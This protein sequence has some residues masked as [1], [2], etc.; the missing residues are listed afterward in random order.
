MSRKQACSHPDCS[1]P[2][3]VPV[4]NGNF[5]CLR[6]VTARVNAPRNVALTEADAEPKKFRDGGGKPS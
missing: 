5:L 1:A 3:V 2:G 4:E 6:H